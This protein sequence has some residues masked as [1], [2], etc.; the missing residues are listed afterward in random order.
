[1]TKILVYFFTNNFGNVC[2]DIGKELI[3]VGD[4]FV[5]A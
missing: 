2:G 4:C 1:M 3:I 5:D